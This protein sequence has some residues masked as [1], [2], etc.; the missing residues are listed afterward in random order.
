MTQP[1]PLA[2]QTPTEIDTHLADIDRRLFIADQV[3]AGTTARAERLRGYLFDGGHTRVTP[4]QL[5]DAEVERDIAAAK[6][7]ALHA[8]AAP[9]RAEYQTRPWSRS[10]IVLNT[11]GH[12]HRGTGPDSYPNCS[13]CFPTTRYGWLPE[14]AGADED[15]ILA[16]IGDTACTVCYP[17]QKIIDGPRTVFAVEEIEARAEADAKAAEKATKAA[18]KAAKAIANPDGSPLRGRHGVIATEVTARNE[19][20]GMVADVTI[21]DRPMDAAD[22]ELA[23]RILAALAHKAG[24]QVEALRTELAAKAAAK[25]KREIAEGEKHARRLGLLS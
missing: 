7:A 21:Y 3:A 1:R 13:T 11:G 16:A 4:E 9:Y 25:A 12:A 22:A 24:A 15:A 8:E 5:R 17:S 6:V 14:L 19:Y 10:W 23:E 20:V 18:A 2:E